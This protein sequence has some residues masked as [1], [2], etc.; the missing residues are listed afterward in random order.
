M[1][2][3]LILLALFVFSF[4]LFADTVSRRE[5]MPTIVSDG[6]VYGGVTFTNYSISEIKNLVLTDD[7]DNNLQIPIASMVGSSEISAFAPGVFVGYDYSPNDLVK[8]LVEFDL[9]FAKKSFLFDVSA[10][11][12]YCPINKGGFHL[13]FGGYVGFMAGSINIGTYTGYGNYY[14]G[15]KTIK[16]G[17]S[18]MYIIPAIS[19]N[20]IMDVT[21]RINEGLAIFAQAGYTFAFNLNNQ[22]SLGD[23]SIPVRDEIEVDAKLGGPKVKVGVT[24]KLNS[25]F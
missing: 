19:L 23:V 1:K 16:N 6:G 14:V 17:D 21:Y 12:L 8:L 10:G 15:G 13:G 11:A 25:L 9:Y 22:L 24:Y 20:P 2:K 3:I 7:Y 5:S 4:S 18:V